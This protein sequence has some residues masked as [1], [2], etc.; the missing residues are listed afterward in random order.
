MADHEERLEA[1][2]SI[3]PPVAPGRRR[4]RWP[5]SRAFRVA[6]A[7]VVIGTVATSV[8]LASGDSGGGVDVPALN[9]PVPPINVASVIPGGAAISDAS[10]QGPAVVVNFWG[11]WCPPCQAEMPIFQAAHRR[12]G[13]RVMFIGIDEG[14]SRSAA[15]S[16]LHKV[17]VTYPIGFD[18]NG[19]AER[20][21]S[22]ASNPVT[23]WISRGRE[24]DFTLGELT[25][26]MLQEN[27]RQWYGVS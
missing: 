16:F 12:L 1:P 2:E 19:S 5:R 9:V 18:G 7:G 6:A 17:G 24:L 27:L 4:R 26:T 3:D 10:L 11:S 14:D 8:V 15:L 25:R 22:I 21:F 23:F 20:S 13:D